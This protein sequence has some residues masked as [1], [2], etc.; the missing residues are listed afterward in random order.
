MQQRRTL[1]FL[2]TEIYTAHYSSRGILFDACRRTH[3]TR[4]YQPS[5]FVTRLLP[6]L[7]ASFKASMAALS[8]AF[9]CGAKPLNSTSTIALVSLPLISDPGSNLRT[10][11]MKSSCKAPISVAMYVESCG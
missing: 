9:V 3:R 10:V 7:P 5:T 6:N 8:S 11:I 4:R 2:T 1:L